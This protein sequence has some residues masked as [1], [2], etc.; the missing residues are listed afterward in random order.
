MN[1]SQ[2]QGSF[3]T[4]FTVGMLAGAAGL[5]LFGTKDGS[6]IRKQLSQEW[7]SAK[8]QLFT[9]GHIDNPQAKLGDIVRDFMNSLT[10]EAS[11]STPKS[12]KSK[13]AVK[14]KSSNKFKN[15]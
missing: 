13:P 3:L 2:D 1:E 14:A 6:K 15:S 4:G 9:Q 5:F 8:L 7:D 11:K 10:V 12:A